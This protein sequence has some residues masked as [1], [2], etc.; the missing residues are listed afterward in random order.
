MISAFVPVGVAPFKK[1]STK[2]KVQKSVCLK[3][4]SAM[5]L[6]RLLLA[7]W[8][9]MQHHICAGHIETSN[10]EVSQLA[11]FYWRV[12]NECAKSAKVE[13]EEEFYRK[14]FGNVWLNLQNCVVFSYPANVIG[15]LM[16]AIPLLFFDNFLTFTSECLPRFM[17]DFFADFVIVVCC[18][19]FAVSFLIFV[20]FSAEIYTW[21]CMTFWWIGCSIV[22]GSRL[23]E[24]VE[25]GENIGV[26]NL[27]TMETVNVK[28][29]VEQLENI[30]ANEEENAT[31][32]TEICEGSLGENVTV[33]RDFCEDN[34]D[35]NVNVETEICETHLEENLSVESEI[36]REDSANLKKLNLYKS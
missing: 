35:E 21:A 28:E 30:G 5:C 29:N 3:I 13:E 20:S 7:L 6:G 25:K 33:E 15:L 1:G 18:S 8:L 4:F 17:K 32:E 2:V 16:T 19:G 26:L 31:V 12:K 11:T 34:L 14:S 27:D 9:P 24:I 36:G 23:G 22:G 10:F